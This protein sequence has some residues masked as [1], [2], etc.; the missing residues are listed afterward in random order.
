MWESSIEVP[1]RKKIS[2]LKDLVDV[3]GKSSRAKIPQLVGTEDSTVLVPTYNW[4]NYLGP[5][6][7]KIP[8][9]KHYHRFTVRCK[10]KGKLTLKEY[11]DSSEEIFKMLCDDWSPTA[12]ISEPVRN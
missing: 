8:H 6:F 2:C 10:S 5:H 9:L 11:G 7:K 3:V 1:S 4:S 12:S